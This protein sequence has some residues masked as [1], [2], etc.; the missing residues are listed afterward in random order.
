[1]TVDQFV[2]KYNGK[3]VD[4]D[5]YYG[6]QCWD[7]AC[8]YTLDLYKFYLPTG[9][10][11]ACGCYTLFRDP[12]P[13]HFNKVAYKSG[14]VPKKGD[15]I[16]WSCSMPRTGGCGHIAIVL[17]ASTRSFVSFDQNWGGMYA[18]KV[19]HN[20]SY[21]MGWLTPKKTTKKGNKMATKDQI[22]KLYRSLLFRSPDKGGLKTY[23]KHSFATVFNSLYGSDERKRKLAGQKATREREV[24]V[25]KKLAKRVEEKDNIIKEL[26]ITIEKLKDKLTVKELEKPFPEGK[27]TEETPYTV[28][29]KFLA[30]VKRIFR[31]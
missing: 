19:N 24:E 5:G 13:K 20:Y 7:L 9:N 14:R 3:A 28:I 17:S 31:R 27:P 16:V 29:D 26:N 11:C 23:A 12:L 1:M 21:V 8:R 25:N 2:R 18:H 6:A 22:T 30:L 10:G 15:I 4:V